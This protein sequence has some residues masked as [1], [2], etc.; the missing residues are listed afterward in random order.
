MMLL[1]S[2][3][4]LIKSCRISSIFPQYGHEPQAS[5]L[6]P[7]TSIPRTFFNKSNDSRA[8]FC[9]EINFQCDAVLLNYPTHLI[10]SGYLLQD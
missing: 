8:K 6:R 7:W 2:W 4:N 9:S 5:G 1:Y 3:L 10:S